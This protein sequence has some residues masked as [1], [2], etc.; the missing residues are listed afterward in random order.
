MSVYLL[1]FDPPYKHAQHYLGFAEG[2]PIYRIRKHRRGA[3][4]ATLPMAAAAA[5]CEMRIAWVWPD[6]TRTD[7]RRLKNRS[8]LPKLCRFCCD[9]DTARRRWRRI[10][11]A[12]P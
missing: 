7:E 4:R 9:L 12:D 11:G 8:H 3:S 10:A 5:G 1:H 2:D 6:G